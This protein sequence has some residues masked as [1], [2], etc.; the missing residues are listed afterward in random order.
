MGVLLL[1]TIKIKPNRFSQYY[2]SKGYII[3]GPNKDIEI[4]V[5][6]LIPTSATKVPCICDFCNNKFLKERRTIK[7]LIDPIA[8]KHCSIYK[9]K[10]TIIEK[11]GVDSVFKD[12]TVRNK[13]KETW[14]N[15]YGV[16]NPSKSQEIIKRRSKTN[17]E[18]Y[19][20]NCSMNGTNKYKSKETFL[21]RYGVDHNSKTDLF[22]E[23]FKITCIKKYGVP[24]PMQYLEIKEKSMLNKK[25]HN[26][27]CSKQQRYI[28]NL[29][30]G[31]I[32]KYINGYYADIFLKNENI[33]IEYDGSGHW[34]A[35]K[36]YKISLIEFEKNEI[37]R[38]NVLLN[39]GYKIL[40]I[41]SRKDLIPIDKEL[42]DIINKCKN[43]F[44]SKINIIKVDIDNLILIYDG[45]NETIKFKNLR[46][47]KEDV[48]V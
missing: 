8:C 21:K 24:N 37:A 2:K 28:N 34:F 5:K 25:T 38:E 30:N 3:I 33:I 45:V 6:D 7:N 14:V 42:I 39:D 9:G 31:E 29:L 15:K 1:E 23:K 18:K 22:K 10:H 16:D 17:F 26:N 44:S 48:N 43:I 47:I 36:H 19:G 27:N 12:I 40:R 46:K 32:N 35:V 11:Y 20:N 13:I 4:K 41:I